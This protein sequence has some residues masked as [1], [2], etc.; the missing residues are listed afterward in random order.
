[1]GPL[2]SPEHRDRVMGYVKIALDEGG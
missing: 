1:M 2:T